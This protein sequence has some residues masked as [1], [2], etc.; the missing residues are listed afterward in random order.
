MATPQGFA[1]E[2][3]EPSDGTLSITVKGEL[4][5]SAAPGL[6]EAIS[7]AAGEGATVVLDLQAVTFLDSSAI[8]ALVAA[9]RELSGRDGRLQVGP[10]S[11]I[12]SKVLE[13]TGLADSSEAFDVLPEES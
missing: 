11:A 4:D 8:G 5:M 7:E 3:G 9:G 12:V 10:R 13:I 2:I 1:V 6:S